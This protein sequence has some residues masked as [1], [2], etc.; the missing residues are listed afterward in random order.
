MLYVQYVQYVL[1]IV[2]IVGIAG[3]MY[4]TIM[5]SP[6]CTYIVGIVGQIGIVALEGVAAAHKRA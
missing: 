6:D 1:G 2:G 4:L 3:K 5:V